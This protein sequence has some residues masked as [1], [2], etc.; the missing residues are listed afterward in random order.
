MLDFLKVLLMKDPYFLLG[1]NNYPPPSYLADLSPTMLSIYRQFLGMVA[2][3]VA[4][5]TIFSTSPLIQ[6]LLLGPRRLGLRGEPWMY[7]TTWGGF[8]VIFTKGLGGI[9]HTSPAHASL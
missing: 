3:I 7:P 1:P 9:L 4:L 2:I 8:N 5:E 6:C